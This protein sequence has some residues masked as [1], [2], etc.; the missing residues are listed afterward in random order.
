MRLASASPSHS[1][2][3]IL[4]PFGHG[5]SYGAEFKYTGLA[6]SAS[7]VSTTGNVQVSFTV[8]LQSVLLAAFAWQ[9]NF[10]K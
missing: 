2:A 10:G 1:T 3:S 5:L 6:L 9:Q 4:Y 8:L 7:T